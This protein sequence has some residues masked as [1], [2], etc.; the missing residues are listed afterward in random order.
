M[1]SRQPFNLKLTLF[2]KPFFYHISPLTIGLNHFHIVQKLTLDIFDQTYT[3]SK[4]KG[5]AKYLLYT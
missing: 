2:F 3:H 1:T 4:M 5:M